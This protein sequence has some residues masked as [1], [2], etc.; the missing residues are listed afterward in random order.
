MSADKESTIGWS[1]LALINA[2]IAQSK[3]RSGVNW[4]FISLLIGPL[5]TL[6]LVSVYR[7]RPD[8][9]AAKGPD[10]VDIERYRAN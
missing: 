6:L 9:P 7:H 4:F 3:K 10:N 2:A 5:A 1:T 8:P